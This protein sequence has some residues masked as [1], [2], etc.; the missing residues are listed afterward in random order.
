MASFKTSTLC[1]VLFCQ[2]LLVVYLDQASAASSSSFTSSSLMQRK[3]R[4]F[5]RLGFWGQNESSQKSST[6]TSSRIVKRKNL[7]RNTNMASFCEVRGGGDTETNTEVNSPSPDTTTTSAS[8]STITTT[9]TT[10]KEKKEVIGGEGEEEEK[11]LPVEPVETLDTSTLTSEQLNHPYAKLLGA[12]LVRYDKETKTFKE[13]ATTDV[14]KGKTTALFMHAQVAEKAL[15][16]HGLTRFLPVIEDIYQKELEK[17]HNF[18]IVFASF[19]REE[20]VYQD[21]IKGMPWSSIPFSERDIITGLA[22]KFQSKTLPRIILFDENA[23]IINEKALNSILMDRDGFPWYP[24]TLQEIIGNEFIASDKET[25][26]AS[27][28][29]DKITGLYFSAN[30]CPPCKQFTPKLKEL[31]NKLKADGKKLEIIYV[32][33]DEN[34]EKF[35]AYFEDMPWLAI[36]YSDKKRLAVLQ[37]ELEIRGLPTLILLDEKGNIITNRGRDFVAMDSDGKNFPW[38]PKALNDLSYSMDGLTDK[39]SIL[40]LEEAVSETEQNEVDKILEPI[41]NEHFIEAK[42]EKEAGKEVV[43][44]DGFKSGYAFFTSKKSHPIGNLMRKLTL[45]EELS[46]KPQVLLLD[47]KQKSFHLSNEPITDSMIRNLISQHKEGTLT[48]TDFIIPEMPVDSTATGEGTPGS[49]EQS[50]ETKSETD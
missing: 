27:I 9:T 17:G 19:D 5:T 3:Q 50:S 25:F 6:S 26:D 47:F 24:K 31:Y 35:D 43:D 38:Y 8:D 34:Q 20:G 13:M 42:Q 22:K 28:L 16:K 21:Y 45:T 12:K 36:P 15:E 37:S 48:M 29:E 10:E 11:P 30:W 41:A 23:E 14:L 40:V 49:T 46:V 33:N 18:E 44:E 4:Q 2:L 7:N 1:L 39:P 32:S